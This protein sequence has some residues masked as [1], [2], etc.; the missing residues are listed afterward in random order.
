[1]ELANG[2]HIEALLPNNTP[3]QAKSF[4]AGD[5]VVVTWRHGASTFLND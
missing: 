5:S 2:I 1:V 3:G 4:E